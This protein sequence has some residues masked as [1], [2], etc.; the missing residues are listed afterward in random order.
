MAA[1]RV[2]KGLAK[3]PRQVR[4][5]IAKVAGEMYR[6]ELPVVQGKA[7]VYALNTILG[8]LNADAQRKQIGGPAIQINLGVLP[9]GERP[10][11]NITPPVKE[12]ET[13]GLIEVDD[14]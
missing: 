2:P 11:I 9:G 12:I 8:S 1:K 4:L 5:F 3:D 7:V 10:E 13:S 6:G 14:D